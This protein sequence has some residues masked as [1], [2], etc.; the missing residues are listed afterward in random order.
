MAPLR[1]PHRPPSY[2]A[3]LLAIC[4]TVALAAS[5][6]AQN[7][8]ESPEPVND[9]ENPAVVGIN[10]LAPRATF[11]TYPDAASAQA[12]KREDSPYFQ[13]L[14]GDWKFHW[15]PKPVDRPT[16]FHEP[17]FDT[18][19]WDTIDVPSNWQMR[20]YGR[21]I[22][23][24]IVYPFEKDPPRIQQHYN[25]VGSYRRD[26][27][28]PRSWRGRDIILH[29]AGVNSAFYVWVNG[30]QVGYSQGSMTPAEFDITPFLAD[31]GANSIAVEVYRW[32]D[33]SYLEDQDM[34][35]L[36]G[37]HRE[38][39]LWAR[40]RLRLEDFEVQTRFDNNLENA[41][42]IVALTL[43]N[44]GQEP[45]GFAFE[46]QLFAPDG[47][48]VTSDSVA[49]VLPGGAEEIITFRRPVLSPARWSAETPNLYT[50]ALTHKGAGN[51]VVECVSVPVGFRKVEIKGGQLLVN[52]TPI[53]IKGVNRHELCPD[54]GQ[55]VT[56]A[57]MIEDI[58]LMKRNNINAV[59]TSH[60]PNQPIW[61]ALC[62]RYGLYL[63]NEANIESH[64]MGY[65]PDVTLGNNPDW[66]L[67]HMDRTIR[68]VERDK[69]HPS[70][71]IWS[72]GN[73]AGDGVNF[74]ATSAWT[75]QRDPS[76][77]VQYEQAGK[78][79]HTDIYCPMYARIDQIVAY[80]MHDQERPLILCEYA[81]AMGNSLGNFQ[82]YWDAIYT[83][84]HLQGGF[85]WDWADQG[86][87]KTDEEGREFWA[88]GGDYGDHPNDGNFCC[89]GLVQPD[90]QPNPSLH[91]LRKVYQSIHTTPIDLE[92]GRFSV[93]NGY[94]FLNLDGFA[95]EWALYGD[96]VELQRGS[97]ARMSLEAGKTALFQVPFVTPQAQPGAEYYL[98]IQYA[99][100]DDTPWAPRGHVVA[101]DEFAL[102]V[103]S[104]EPAYVNV[105][106]MPALAYTQYE[107]RIDVEGRDFRLTIETRSGA[108][109][110]FTVGT[111]ELLSRPLAPNFWRVP[112]DND[113]GNGMPRR[114]EVWKAAGPER[115]LQGISVRRLRPEAVHV[116]VQYAL[117]AGKATL[118]TAYTI[119]GSGDVIVENSLLPGDEELPELPRFG[120]I[121]ELPGAFEKMTWYGRGPHETYWD[122][123]TGAPVGLY[124]GQV[125]EQVHPYVRPQENANKTDVRWV[126]FTDID[127]H[128]LMAIG[129]PQLYVTAWPYTVE[130]LDKAS[131]AYQMPR[132][133]LVT[134]Q[135]DMG[136]T[137]V[138]GDNS[139]GARPLPQYT[140]Y[141]R[142]MRY[143]FRLRPYAPAMGDMRLVARN[144]IPQPLV[145]Q[146]VFI[147][148]DRKGLVSLQCPT[149]SIDIRY[150]LDGSDPVETSPPYTAPFPLEAGGVVKARAFGRNGYVESDIVTGR[151]PPLDARSRWRVINVDSV[152]PGLGDAHFAI[153]GDPATCWITNFTAT[154]KQPPHE[155]QIDMTR[156]AALTGFAYTPRQDNSEGRIARY[157]FYVSDNGRDWGEPVAAGVFPDSADIQ[158]VRFDQPVTGR[159]LRLVALS[160]VNGGIL[161]AVAEI[162]VLKDEGID[163]PVADDMR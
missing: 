44:T 72:L 122:R 39:F 89:N 104:P 9:W 53:Y 67:A 136:Q 83:Y 80:A 117:P 156:P 116:R 119:Y 10:R 162:D 148:R 109:E 75:R 97:L 134:L 23:T 40:P 21:P 96:G 127:G 59:R 145:A 128:G 56:E 123:R 103:Q 14:N 77:P 46:A 24:N 66:E 144:T 111:R 137:G 107:D 102:P 69:N 25:P 26:F 17:D 159:Y 74:E 13:S 38:V 62:D 139:W 140:L 149:P 12:G 138:G 28:I 163:R 35:R 125:H 120:M 16:R 150:T 51:Q 79:P 151:F 85:V 32:C 106:A 130:D 88:Y 124:S 45:E 27:S 92:R 5:A 81:H 131:H 22:Y 60:Y 153:D 135:L 41:D 63:V 58:L 71:I 115:R 3:C 31:R 160:E 105:G 55:A 126:A 64:G 90:R 57:K 157:E 152:E 18:S 4:L 118:D 133:E 48:S 112:I 86:L 101:W 154:R 114:Q 42:L 84:K 50:L 78:R 76:R 8:S 161:T 143:S 93:K 15:A 132:R 43:R 110:S 82:E 100:G 158:R 36:S 70:V 1:A 99:L 95:I 108:L 87:R 47:Q 30:E 61:Y 37:I 11:M 20:G 91:E 6:G 113:I 142:P 7:A 65:D 49:S 19:G 68:M 52:G 129:M 98:R 54:E 33:G 73:E 141:A 146:P 2:S 147:D 121:T 34:W 94:G 155:I 29:F